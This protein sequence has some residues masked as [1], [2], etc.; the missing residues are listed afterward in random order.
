VTDAR[1][2]Y[3]WDR[4]GPPDPDVVRLERALG[5]FRP[6]PATVGVAAGPADAPL[7]AARAP[8]RNLSRLVFRFAVAASVLAALLVGLAWLARG[9]GVPGG[10]SS[11]QASWAVE[12]I[13]GSPLVSSPDG[14]IALTGTTRAAV[15]RTIVTDERSR[16]RVEIAALG[17]VEVAPKSRLR[18]LGTSESEHRLALDR[19][20]L[21]AL[22]RAP[23]RRFFVETPHAIAADLGCAFTLDVADDGT[24]VLRV[25]SGYVAFERQGIEAVVPAGAECRAVPGVG[26]GTPLFFDAPQDL[27]DAL[28]RFDFEGSRE[29]DLRAALA[30]ARPR[31]A[32]SVWHLLVRARGDARA[33]AYE[34]LAALAPPPATVTRDAVMKMEK[35][36]LEQWRDAIR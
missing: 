36:A 33:R 27:R 23:P 30:A 17:H 21:S 7:D 11:P 15:G 5:E 24:S 26:P 18:L 22:T 31:D 25:T 19:G 35:S 20:R 4:S 1:D 2:D 8:L 9:D 12:A 34:R 29:E 3:L 13:A 28:A 10:G 32:L 14:D 16:A 6:G